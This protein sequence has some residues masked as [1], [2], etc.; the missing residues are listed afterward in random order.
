MTKRMLWG[1]PE[2]IDSEYYKLVGLVLH[3]WDWNW[4]GWAWVANSLN[5]EYGNNRSI[6][7]C[8][9]K[10]YKYEKRRNNRAEQEG[11]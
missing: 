4:P 8:M 9:Q 2:D 10:F 6:K 5:R 7:A 1:N 3:G 11:K